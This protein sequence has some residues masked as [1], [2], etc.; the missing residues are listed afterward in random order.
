MGDGGSLLQRIKDVK[1]VP[2]PA[3]FQAGPKRFRQV[4]SRRSKYLYFQRI[5]VLLRWFY[6]SL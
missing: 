2:A 1:G 3:P 6:W 5:A 4:T